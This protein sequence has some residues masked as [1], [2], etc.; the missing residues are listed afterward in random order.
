MAVSDRLN[1]LIEQGEDISYDAYKESL[2]RILT[3]NTEETVTFLNELCSGKQLDRIS[4]VLDEVIS[5][6]RSGELIKALYKAVERYL[7][8]AKKR[9]VLD[10]IN[11]A[12]DYLPET[13]KL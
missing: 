12:K 4:E 2:I 9:Y 7:D 13:D 10:A 6:S 1:N 3:E 5:I 11:S 8:I